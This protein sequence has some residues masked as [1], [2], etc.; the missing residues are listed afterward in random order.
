MKVA[1]TGTRKGMSDGQKAQMVYLA[2]LLERPGNEWHHGAAEGADTE[3]AALVGEF[4]LAWVVVPH[5]GGADPLWRNRELVALCDLLVAAPETD[6]E[7]V[8]SGTWATV[9][10]ARHVGKPVVMLSRGR[11]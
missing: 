6:Q 11:G 2:N 8:R 4:T 1:F 7:V 3:A 9:R 10:Y 5:P